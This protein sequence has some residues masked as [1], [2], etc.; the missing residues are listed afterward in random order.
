MFL[1]VPKRPLEQGRV[2]I[3]ERARQML[4]SDKDVLEAEAGGYGGHEFELVG[5]SYRW[6]PMFA[7]SC[8]TCH[9]TRRVLVV[10]PFL[11]RR[12]V[13]QSIDFRLA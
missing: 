13:I 7:T 1:Y 3:C 5:C 8:R 10:C 4:A 11:E 12:A 6:L 9:S 2:G